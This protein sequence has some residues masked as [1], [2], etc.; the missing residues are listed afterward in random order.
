VITKMAKILISALG[1]GKL[2][3][4]NISARGYTR[5]ELGERVASY[6]TSKTTRYQ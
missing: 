6:K 3:K 4:N 2:E 5:A 1:T